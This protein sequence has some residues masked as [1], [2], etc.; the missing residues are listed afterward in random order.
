VSVAPGYTVLGVRPSPRVEFLATG[1]D[2]RPVR[3]TR[4]SGYADL[5]A[6]RMSAR[7]ER[8]EV[9][10]WLPDS[11]A[12]GAEVSDP[13]TVLSVTVVPSGLAT[14]AD[15]PLPAV[16]DARAWFGASSDSQRIAVALGINRAAVAQ[17]VTLV[18]CYHVDC[19]VPA[20]A[21]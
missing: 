17:G 21:P 4:Y 5:S 1:T 13:A 18:V 8:H 16:R 14:A 20:G 10:F 19:V 15:F 9:S 3:I 7:E 11:D 12:Y 2:G 6:P